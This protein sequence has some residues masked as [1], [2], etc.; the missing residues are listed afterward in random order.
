VHPDSDSPSIRYKCY[1]VTTLALSGAGS[2]TA[3]WLVSTTSSLA[4][5][6]GGCPNPSPWPWPCDT[7][8]TPALGPSLSDTSPFCLSA[9]SRS[10]RSSSVHAGVGDGV[11]CI[12][13]GVGVVG[14]SRRCFSTGSG[15]G[16]RGE[17]TCLNPPPPPPC[18]SCGVTGTGTGMGA[19]AGGCC[20]V[21]DRD[22]MPLRRSLEKSEGR[23][24]GGGGTAARDEP[25]GTLLG[26]RGSGDDGT[27]VGV[28]GRGDMGALPT[29]LSPTSVSRRAVG[30]PAVLRTENFSC[31]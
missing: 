7:P 17:R 12:G 15:V 14:N 23:F 3:I 2:N 22:S 20:V 5:V 13:N 29:R 24:A 6:G 28:V 9:P 19:G 11:A 21:V 8:S 10:C 25:S 30:A 18:F 1:V 31:R 4:G 26:G 16:E 27:G